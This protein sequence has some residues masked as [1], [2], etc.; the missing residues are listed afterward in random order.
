MKQVKVLVAESDLFVATEL[1]VELE[2]QGMTLSG[3]ASSLEETLKAIEE[4]QTDFVVLN[5]KCRDGYNYPAAR[6]LLTLGIPFVFLTG[7]DG[8]EIPPEFDDVPYL[9]KPLDPKSI[10][11]SV[12]SL[13]AGSLASRSVPAGT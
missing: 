3:I 9:S 13:V 2:K 4:K 5:I 1:A 12:V 8:R 10:A 11:A 7:F 6:R